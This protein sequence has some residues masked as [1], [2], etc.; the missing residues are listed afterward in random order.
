MKKSTKL[1]SVILAV[2]MIFSSLS[3]ASF[4]AGKTNYKTVED[5]TALDAYN[6]YGSV[7]R[8]TTEERMSI[9]FDQLDILLGELNI[10]LGTID[11]SI[12]GKLTI[13]LT[14][15]NALCKTV[16]NVKKFVEGKKGL[17]WMVGVAENINV[18]TWQSGMTRETTSQIMIVTELLELLSA[19]EPLVSAVLTK[20]LDLGV[21]NNFLPFDRKGMSDLIKDLPGTIKALI[22]PLMARR[23]ATAS[24]IGTFTNTKGNGGVLT[25]LDSFVQTLFTKPMLWTSYRVNA[26]GDDLKYTAELPTAA[27]Q[28]L[29]Y[30]VVENGGEQISQYDYNFAPVMGSKSNAGTWTKTVTYT[31]TLETEGE[32][33]YVYAAPKDYTGDQTLKWYKNGDKGYLLPSVRDAIN[34]GAL[35]F[36]VNGADSALGLLYKF[37]PYVFAEMAAVVLNG[38]V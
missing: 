4:A 23:D 3:V 25:V 9:L 28:T 19:N 8:L 27:G 33:I 34:S 24:E 26:N 5:L 6:P 31:K 37:I 11:L 7:T 36:S 21:A 14:S 30:F 13:D 20:G 32:D 16:D 15:I 2:L 22:F 1:L 17:L 12:L 38:S 29:R 18:S 35:T 10:N